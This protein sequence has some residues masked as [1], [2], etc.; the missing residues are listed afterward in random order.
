[1]KLGYKIVI[2]ALIVAVGF[3]YFQGV[4]SKREERYITKVNSIIT[5]IRHRDYFAFHKELLP[6]L[7]QKVSIERIQEYMKH[8]AIERDVQF[9]INDISK[10]SDIITLNGELES[11]KSSIPLEM[12]FQEKNNTL[13]LISPNIANQT[14]EGVD[15]EFPQP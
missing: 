4:K 1:L 14:I 6:E 15:L 5:N 9:H 7:A 3:F 10:K 2:I 8:F 11:K 12:I 13:Y